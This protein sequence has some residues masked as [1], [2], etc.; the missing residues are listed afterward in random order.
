MNRLAVLL[1]VLTLMLS[2][3][4]CINP[5]QADVDRLTAQVAAD[6]K[7]I[8]NQTKLIENLT[9]ELSDLKEGAIPY[10]DIRGNVMRLRNQQNTHDPESPELFDFLFYDGTDRIPYRPPRWVCSDYAIRLHDNAER[11]GIR[12][13]VVLL[14]VAPEAPLHMVTSFNVQSFGEVWIDEVGY[15]YT[16]ELPSGVNAS[17]SPTGF[18][19]GY[20]RIIEPPSDSDSSA[21]ALW[22]GDDAIVAIT[23][24][25]EAYVPIKRW[26]MG[27]YKY[28]LGGYAR[29]VADKYLINQ[30]GADTDQ[31]RLK[32]KVHVVYE[33]W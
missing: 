31:V 5:L 11:K 24:D 22:A 27:S 18:I 9:K 1:I 13:G 33:R 6:N 12:A 10:K 4:A 29:S 14:D 17:T 30:A 26:S 16:F 7:T 28:D 19:T 21:K 23:R 8:S 3:I 20:S 2:A 32:Q 15:W 25:G